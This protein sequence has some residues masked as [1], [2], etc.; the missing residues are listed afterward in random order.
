MTGPGLQFVRVEQLAPAEVEVAWQA[1]SGKPG[2]GLD[3]AA[4]GGATDRVWWIQATGETLQLPVPCRAGSTCAPA[5]DHEA[6]MLFWTEQPVGMTTTLG[7]RR[8]P[9][10]PASARLATWQ[11]AIDAARR[12]VPGMNGTQAAIAG[13]RLL[14]AAQEQAIEVA[15]G[16]RSYGLPSSETPLWVVEL[17]NADFQPPGTVPGGR[18]YS[19]IVVIFDAL[20]GASLGYRSPAPAASQPATSSP[21]TP[22]P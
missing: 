1:Y 13:L 14:T 12:W 18:S 10:L 7:A 4:G 6:I 15:Q 17:D 8:T 3:P 11:D 9:L 5:R 22:T 2:G 20:T 21:A 19:R 16:H